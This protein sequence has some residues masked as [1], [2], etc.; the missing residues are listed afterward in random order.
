MTQ[1]A[2]E[3]LWFEV[4]K[5]ARS[6]NWAERLTALIFSIT[7]FEKASEARLDPA[8]T[9]KEARKTLNDLITDLAWTGVLSKAQASSMRSIN[10]ARNSLI[11]NGIWPPA[12]LPIDALVDEVRSCCETIKAQTVSKAMAGAL[13]ER[14]RRRSSTKDVLL[15]GSLA[16]DPPTSDSEDIGLLVFDDGSV[17]GW[18]REIMDDVHTKGATARS[19]PHFVS[20]DT[21]ARFLGQTGAIGISSNHDRNASLD[22]Y[23][24]LGVNDRQINAFIQLGW[25]QLILLPHPTHVSDGHRLIQDFRKRHPNPKFLETAL[26]DAVHWDGEHFGP[27]SADLCAALQKYMG[28]AAIPSNRVVT[29]PGQRL[30]LGSTFRLIRP[31]RTREPFPRLNG[32]LALHELAEFC[33]IRPSTAASVLHNAGIPV[34]V[35]MSHVEPGVVREAMKVLFEFVVR[36]EAEELQEAEARVAPEGENAVD[37]IKG[38]DDRLESVDHSEISDSCEIIDQDK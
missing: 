11:H 20:T 22:T 9:S 19:E 32:Q 1:S 4:L 31:C 24:S 3:T 8:L 12:G 34:S 14:L 37:E 16:R 35:H 17:S 33:H 7:I 13:A 27:I 28:E 2:Q 21:F 5:A 36:P 10:G 6:E 25:M 26:K 29:A 30:R 23:I 18:A 38:I 15:F